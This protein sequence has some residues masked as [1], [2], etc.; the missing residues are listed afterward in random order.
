MR[1]HVQVLALLAVA[2]VGWRKADAQVSIR[3]SLA[4]VQSAEANKPLINAGQY[5]LELGP[6][7]AGFSANVDVGYN[8]N[9]DLSETDRKGSLLI[10]PGIT[11]N[12]LWQATEYN[13]FHLNLGAGYVKYAT[14]PAFNSSSLVITPDSQIGFDIY[15]GDFKFTI[16]DQLSIQ[17]NPL[18]I[19]DISQVARL[20]RLENSAGLNVTWD[21]D[22]VIL[23]G[24]YAHYIF[25]S[26]ESAYD[27]LNENENQLY[28]SA[29]VR[30][31]DALA[32]GLRS[33]YGDVEYAQNFQNNSFN[34]SVGMFATAQL[35]PYLRGEGEIGY[36]GAHYDTGGGNG[37]TTSQLIAPYFHLQL[38]H[39]LNRYWTEHLATGYE[40]QLGLTTNYTE[41]FYVRF[42]GDWRVN[43]RT[44]ASVSGYYE[45]S[46]DS[47]GPDQSEH[48]NRVGVGIRWAF[49]L[50]RKANLHFNYDFVNNSS[51]LTEHSFYQ[52][53]VLLGIGYV[54]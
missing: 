1:Q 49:A 20:L 27:F 22:Q 41:V 48:I 28:L 13:A 37:D 35:T 4:G 38:D 21:L 12:V 51:D 53:Q 47:P 10:E 29:S 9:I 36:Q 39:R 24:G 50:G 17:Q 43:S 30:L 3:P 18:E 34:Y 14:Y 32:V 11:A 25:Y 54:F 2:I 42:D 8:D 6:V 5:N 15:V 19:I 23:F 45:H 46:M 33:T 44:T 31:S 7:L 26:F 52:N 40:T 16:F